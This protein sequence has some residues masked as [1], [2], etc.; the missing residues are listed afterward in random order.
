MQA[1]IRA[2]TELSSWN[3]RNAYPRKHTST[4]S[5]CTISV[6]SIHRRLIYR[7]QSFTASTFSSQK[8]VLIWRFSAFVDTFRWK[9]GF[10]LCFVGPVHH[11]VTKAAETWGYFIWGNNNRRRMI[12]EHKNQ[13][14]KDI[15]K[16]VLLSSPSSMSGGKPPTNTLRE[17]R[18]MRSPFW[19]G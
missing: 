8:C 14:Y 12:R 17:K 16:E 18:S 9:V 4:A 15:P 7:H 6:I 11:Q 10:A 13:Q 5:D 2:C 19:W 1:S 3:S